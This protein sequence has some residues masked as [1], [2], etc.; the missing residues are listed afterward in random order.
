[1]TARIVASPVKAT[2]A[3]ELIY[4]RDLSAYSDRPETEVDYSYVYFNEEPEDW[5]IAELLPV[6]WTE[7]ER[8]IF[9]LN[10]EDLE[11]E[12]EPVYTTQSEDWDD[13]ILYDED[14][15]DSEEVA[16]YA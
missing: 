11:E 5:Q 15:W 6:G 1:M 9:P 8:R 12:I 4:S 7:L 13:S 2:H 10:K 14:D 3:V 16:N